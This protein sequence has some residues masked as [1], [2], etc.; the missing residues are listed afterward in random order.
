ME[1]K[2]VSVILKR[3]KDQTVKSYYCPSCKVI[4][5]KSLY[6]ISKDSLY[7]YNCGQKL[8]FFTKSKKELVELGILN[9]HQKNLLDKVDSILEGKEYVD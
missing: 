6:R 9:D 1:A 3:L 4:L 5:P 7:C 2:E 8:K